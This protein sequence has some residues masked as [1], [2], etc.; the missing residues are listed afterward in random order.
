GRVE[1]EAAPGQSGRLLLGS[2]HACPKVGRLAAK[3]VGI[4]QH[5]VRLDALEDGDQRHFY[6]A[7]D[8][9]QPGLGVQLRSQHPVQ[10]QGDVRVLGG[11][12]QCLVQADLVEG[13]LL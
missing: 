10:A 2:Q 4:H 1:V 6:P 5:A 8:P 11:I 3:L 9:L 12:A 13:D 7:V